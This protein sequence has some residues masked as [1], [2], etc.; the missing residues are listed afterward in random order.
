MSYSREEL[1]AIYELGR[2]YFEMGYFSPAE[3]IFAGLCVV[4]KGQTPS[5]LALGLVKIERG[6]FDEA[7]QCLRSSLESGQYVF[8]VELALCVSFIASGDRDRA[9]S[10]L[11]QIE[12][13]NASELGL[14]KEYQRLWDA[15]L[16]RC[17]AGTSR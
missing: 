16:A 9:Y 17:Q 5:L 12:K 15:L 3:R 11:R 13:E 4:D 14:Y 2:L 7:A 8:Q 6:R 1:N 10:L